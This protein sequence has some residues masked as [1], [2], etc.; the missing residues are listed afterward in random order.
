[1]KICDIYIQSTLH[2]CDALETKYIK[3]FDRLYNHKSQKKV[4]NRI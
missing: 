1:M 3:C 4:Q 2:V